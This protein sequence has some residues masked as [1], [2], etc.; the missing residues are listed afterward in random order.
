M[1]APL[2]KSISSPGRF[3]AAYELKL[4]MAY[5]T[6]HYEIEPFSERPENGKFSDFQVGIMH[7]LR[8]RRRKV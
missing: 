4:I 3:L 2:T 7:D 5:I 1:S 8:V 6:M